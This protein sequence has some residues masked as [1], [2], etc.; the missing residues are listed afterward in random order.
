MWQKVVEIKIFIISFNLSLRDFSIQMAL[1]N[2]QP[3]ETRTCITGSTKLPLTIMLFFNMAF[4][5]FIFAYLSARLIHSRSSFNVPQYNGIIDTVRV[6][7]S[8]VTILL[9]LSKL[10]V[11]Y[12]FS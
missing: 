1:K 11:V 10:D 7:F 6:F 12:S 2:E 4:R 9:I 5:V 8:K 3:F